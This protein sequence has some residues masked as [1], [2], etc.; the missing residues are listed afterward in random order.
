MHL[1]YERRDSEVKNI[2]TKLQ[3]AVIFLRVNDGRAL[4]ALQIF[5]LAAAREAGLCEHYLR[6]TLSHKTISDV[7]NISS[8]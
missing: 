4:D 2:I 7:V 3:D 8:H 5:A 1:R 6:H